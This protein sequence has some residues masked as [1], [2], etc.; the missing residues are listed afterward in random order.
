MRTP[1][2]ILSIFMMIGIL[3]LTQ[4]GC[5]RQTEVD[6]TTGSTAPSQTNR[7][8]KVA[9]RD[10]GAVNAGLKEW[11][12]DVKTE[13]EQ[14]HPGVAV[15]FVPVQASEAD[16]FAKM[17]L[18]MK[19][20][21]T[22]PDVVTEDTFI[23][24]ADAAAGYL[25]PLDNRI[26]Q[27]NEWNQFFES[28]K[29]AVTGSDGRIY[30]VPYST[31]TRGLWYNVNI[32]KKAGLPVPWQP[33]SWNEILQAAQTIK[34]K[35]PGVIPFWAN[36]GKATGEATTMQTFLMLLYGTEDTLYDEA[37][38][39][40]I[41]RSKGFLDSLKFIHTIFQQKLGPDLSFVLN[42]NA[43]DVLSTQ[44]MPQEKVAIALNGN[45]VPAVWR[46]GGPA[47][48]PE[49]IQVYRLAPMP[50][51]HGQDPGYTSMS[52]GWALSIPANA[53]EKDLAW[54]FIKLATSK[55]HALT[56]AL[57]QGDLT[58]RKDVAEDPEYTKNP[59]AEQATRFLAFTH[60]RPTYEQ[61][62]TISTQIQ[63]AVEAVA[64]G[65]LTPEQA[66]EQYAQNV[67]RIVGGDRVISK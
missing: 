26:A 14:Q 7:T 47:P 30:G 62:P 19:S 33:R 18:M 52:G 65:T 67:T 9:F 63:A 64:T 20:P 27:W 55:R 50:T 10:F 24:K 44:L 39:K 32:F 46:E 34:E 6:N 56:Y 60:F 66:M 11:L 53:K 23:I 1:K 38:H 4:S 42:A 51:Q 45:W 25:E 54:E 17:A 41:I 57:R 21:D 49:G 15:E 29:Q 40:W 16:F 61:Y 22:A 13:F 28:V 3:A 8:V 43:G 31:D 2:R 59:V 36:V 35:V 58:T 12:T 5:G 37:Q 48:W